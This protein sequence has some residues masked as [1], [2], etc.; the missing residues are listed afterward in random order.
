MKINHAVLCYGWGEVDGIKVK[1]T[2]IG[3]CRIHGE[4]DGAKE[5]DSE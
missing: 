3:Y 4:K 2:S 1:V 5:G